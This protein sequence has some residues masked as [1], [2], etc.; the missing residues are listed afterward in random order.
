[1]AAAS[2]VQPI[3]KNASGVVSR[4]A[5]TFAPNE[6]NVN[7][8]F[9]SAEPS[10]CSP[11]TECR[12]QVPLSEP[13]NRFT[14]INSM[15]IEFAVQGSDAED[16][17]VR[18]G[19]ALIRDLR[20]FLDNVEVVRCD[21]EA[22]LDLMFRESLREVYNPS[23]ALHIAGI[24]PPAGD[25]S[26]SSIVQPGFETY[27]T[28]NQVTYAF[29]RTSVPG[30]VSSP[31]RY[32]FQL[33]LDRLFGTL[34]KRFD[35]RRHRE[36]QI[37]IQWLPSSGPL[38][39]LT[40]AVSFSAASGSWAA[41]SLTG[42]G[43]RVFRS[44]YFSPAASIHMHPR[45]HLTYMLRRYDFA[46]LAADLTVAGQLSWTI[47]LNSIFPARDNCTRVLWWLSPPAPTDSATV[48]FNFENTAAVNNLHTPIYFD[49]AFQGT[50]V[51]RV[52]TGFELQRHNMNWYHKT[53]KATDEFP[54]HPQSINDFA[55]INFA[56]LTSGYREV[57]FGHD[58]QMGISVG[59]TGSSQQYVLTLRT[60]TGR[61]ALTGGPTVLN[62]ALESLYKVCIGPGSNAGG[63][64]PTIRTEGL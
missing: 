22:E 3:G 54:I 50:L 63:P 47:N 32:T 51:Q 20:V 40:R 7:Q 28:P 38:A 43:L 30:V 48:G 10:T 39:S 53:H 55:N 34:F 8:A 46:T 58:L 1:M 17:Q 62:I 49:I 19:A 52:S 61:P 37:R 16:I 23:N 12:I 21:Q 31:M 64:L 57:D 35:P 18:S 33:A 29:K 9:Y 4:P 15:A 56:D 36:L 26:V 27:P 14:H 41:C 42:I 11:G 59:S 5:I 25:A 2:H 60:I 24:V 13:G 6:D 45:E 44:V